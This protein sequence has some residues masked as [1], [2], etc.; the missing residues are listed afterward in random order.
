MFV[1]HCIPRIVNRSLKFGLPE[2]MSG[3][4]QMQQL[5]I[6]Q[7]VDHIQKEQPHEF[8]DRCFPNIVNWSL[9]FSLPKFL[10]YDMEIQ[11]TSVGAMV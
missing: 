6:G 5:H 2:F 3:V 4:M 9:K 11:S 10:L 8:V 1:D 7:G